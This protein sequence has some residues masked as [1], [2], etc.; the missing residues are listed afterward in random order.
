MI[1]LHMHSTVS[2]GTFSPV[3]LVSF[4][5]DKGFELISLTDHDCI[6]GLDS[7]IN[8]GKKLSIKTIPGV[9]LSV[10]FEGK[11]IHLLGYYINRHDDDLNKA[12]ADFRNGRDDRNQLIVNRLN[13][14]GL[15]ITMESVNEIAGGDVVGR[16]HIAKAL[17]KEGVV[18]NIKEAF[19]KYLARGQQA[20]FER[21]RLSF[22]DGIKLVLNTGGIPVLAH[23]YYFG[24]EE[25]KP[26]KIKEFFKLCSLKGIKGIEVYHSDIAPKLG[27]LFFKI[28]RELGLIATCGSDFHGD[29]KDNIAMGQSG[30]SENNMK[31]IKEE[32]LKL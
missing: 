29:N 25:S 23:P 7:F 30:C 21:F 10:N 5:A 27:D 20:Y 16:P 2:D 14:L 28:A 8:M 24:L 9:E 19:N 22:E 3:E 26:E 11:S 6:E 18:S 17:L 12:L 15:S 13:E 4:A 32:I 31:I 1:D